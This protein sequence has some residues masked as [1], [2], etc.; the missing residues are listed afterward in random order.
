MPSGE[1]VR[2]GA[3]ASCR[4]LPRVRG[5]WTLQ[6]YGGRAGGALHHAA[7]LTEAPEARAS[8]VEPIASDPAIVAAAA[9]RRPANRRTCALH[10]SRALPVGVERTK[11]TSA[12]RWASGGNGRCC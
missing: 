4:C 6:S 8:W 7:W 1:R 11:L 12:A 10:H 3:P 5:V 2:P 9:L